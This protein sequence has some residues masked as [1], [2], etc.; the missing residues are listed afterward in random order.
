MREVARGAITITEPAQSDRYLWIPVDELFRR[1]INCC[2]PY[3]VSAPHCT[4]GRTVRRLIRM[5][6]AV[7]KSD[8]E[9]E[10]VGRADEIT[11]WVEET[12]QAQVAI[13]SLQIHTDDG[14]E[15]QAELAP[16][17]LTLPRAAFDEVWA[18]T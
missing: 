2:A 4:N 9:L 17:H 18:A 13:G 10:A 7:L 12:T 15:K 6:G 1:K 16:L 14:R 11:S 5:S 8:L 3:S